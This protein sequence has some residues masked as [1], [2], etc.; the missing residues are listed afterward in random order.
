MGEVPADKVEDCC[1]ERLLVGIG[2]VQG[3]DG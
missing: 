2:A 3:D 1:L